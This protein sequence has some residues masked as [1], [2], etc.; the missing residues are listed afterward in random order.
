VQIAESVGGRR[1]IV[2]HVGSARD[3]G[4]LGLLIEQA[5]RLLAGERQGVLDLGITPPVRKATM[6]GQG[7]QPVLF[8]QGLV[9][10]SGPQSRQVVPRPRQF[11]VCH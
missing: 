7:G 2:R 8:S 6:V 10:R 1:R 4:E 5:R 9:S 3:E 11:Q